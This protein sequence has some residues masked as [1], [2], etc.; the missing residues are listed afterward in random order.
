MTLLRTLDKVAIVKLVGI[1]S[2]IGRMYRCS[3]VK[4]VN[5]DQFHRKYTNHP[6]LLQAALT[7]TEGNVVLRY[8]FASYLEGTSCSQFSSLYFSVIKFK[9]C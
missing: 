3:L 4:Y 8:I 6:E 7:Y 5:F 2:V 1:N 9:F